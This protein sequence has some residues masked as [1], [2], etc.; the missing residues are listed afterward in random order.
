MKQQQY[1]GHRL[2]VSD[3][4]KLNF[5][6]NNEI[7]RSVASK[8]I[9]DPKQ[10][11]VSGYLGKRNINDSVMNQISRSTA[12]NIEDSSHIFQ[13]LPDTKVAMEIWVSS[14]LSPKDG[15]TE[16]LIWSISNR[17]TEYS[18]ELFGELLNVVR[19][20]FEQEY[21]LID[22]VKPAIENSLFKTGSYPLVVIPES[23]IDD[24]VNGKTM[25]SNESLVDTFYTKDKEGYKVPQIGLLGDG[26]RKRNVNVGL[27]GLINNA[28]AGQSRQQRLSKQIHPGLTVTD[29]PDILKFK[30][31]LEQNTRKQRSQSIR[32]RYG[33][34]EYANVDLSKND[35]KGHSILR[36]NQQPSD[37][38][39]KQRFD[40]RVKNQIT[41]A[42]Y[43]DRAYTHQPISVLTSS[44]DS[45]R[46]GVGHPLVLQVPSASV[47][48][49]HVPGNPRDIIGAFIILDEYGNPLDPSTTTD[50]YTESKNQSRERVSQATN[51]L[52]QMNFYKEGCCNGISTGNDRETLNELAKVYGSLIE[53]DL[54]NRLAQ[55]VNGDNV[56][57]TRVEEIWRIMLARA[58]SAQRT[59]LLYC[60]EELLTYFAFDYNKYGIGKS[61]LEDGRTLATLRAT[62]MYADLYSGI[63]NSIGRKRVNI[64]FDEMDPNPMKTREVI[65]SE[66]TR[67]NAWN[68]PLMS[69]GPVDAINVLREANVDVV[70][71]G[72][73]PAVP[74][75]EVEVEDVQLQRPNVDDQLSEKIKNMH[76]ASLELPASIV[77][78]TQQTQF[79]TTA[80]TAHSLFNKRVAAK[81]RIINDDLLH[82]HVCKYV[83]N[84]GTLIRRLSL[85]IKEHK[86]LLTDKQR[87]VSNTLEIIEDFLTVLSV[88]LPSPDAM[89]VEDQSNDISRQKGFID[90]VVD[91]LYP[92]EVLSMILPEEIN[93][94]SSLVRELLKSNLIAQYVDG[95]G[96]LPELGRLID[97]DNSND[98]IS[99]SIKSY[100]A[101]LSHLAVESILEFDRIRKENEDN[102]LKGALPEESDSFGGGDSSADDSGSD[103]FGGGDDDFAM[104]DDELGGSEEDDIMDGASDDISDEPQDDLIE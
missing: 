77:D 9:R 42:L 101:P 16:S 2:D 72:N 69:E 70:I 82:D 56:K 54:L 85:K 29:N 46:M 76:I 36:E 25:V 95:N 28:T 65:L 12:N 31:A 15:M 34:E 60:P 18:A 102:A 32:S 96:Y 11:G 86:E 20:Y 66:Y 81:Q 50:L 90:T 45:S 13:T 103:E 89:R 27:E 40:T 38:E 68:M 10:S 67:A 80:L 92:D 41:Q 33:L 35:E 22:I 21:N 100:L 104:G 19:D 43:K 3:F 75:T 49:V 97:L 53:E 52:K 94:K 39:S 8:L 14:L 78:E 48:P 98:T 58:L 37:Q 6:R 74:N 63:Q 84:S 57:L 7:S 73:H 64:T 4:R 83:M 62:L 55:G 30:I 51:I 61:L 91:A 59:Q 1:H 87:G 24:I 88:E 26:Y 17:N 44:K 47:I 99:A 71:Q 23:S 79:A 5:I 93:D